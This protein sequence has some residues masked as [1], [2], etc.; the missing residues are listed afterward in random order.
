LVSGVPFASV[1]KSKL[2][3]PSTPAPVEQ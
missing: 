2:E 1:L 3:S